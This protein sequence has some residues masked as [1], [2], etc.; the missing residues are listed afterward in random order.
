MED[1]EGQNRVHNEPD[2]LNIF[3][4]DAEGQTRVQYKPNGPEF[5]MKDVDD[6]PRFNMMQNAQ[7]FIE[8]VRELLDKLEEGNHYSNGIEFMKVDHT[9]REE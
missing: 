4:K 5:H 2:V 6:Q 9:I 3:M 8:Q 1:A 7:N